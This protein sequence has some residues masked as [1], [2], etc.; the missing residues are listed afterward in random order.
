MYF[1]TLKTKNTKHKTRNSY[2]PKGYGG[3]LGVPL[4]VGLSARHPQR[5]HPAS[6]DLQSVL[7]FG[8]QIANRTSCG[9]RLC[10]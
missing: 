6:A 8:A 7:P 5:H 2:S 1:I 4:R 3:H 9:W 10:G